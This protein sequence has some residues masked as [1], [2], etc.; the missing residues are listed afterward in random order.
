MCPPPVNP[1]LSPVATFYVLAISLY[2]A[3]VLVQV[4]FGGPDPE[5]ERNLLAA[6]RS[7]HLF[8]VPGG[9][10][11]SQ[12]EAAGAAGRRRVRRR[13]GLALAVCCRALALLSWLRSWCM[14]QQLPALLRTVCLALA[15]L[16]L[17]GSWVSATGCYLSYASLLIAA[18][19]LS[20]FWPGMA[21]CTLLHYIAGEHGV[22]VLMQ[23]KC[24]C[25][26]MSTLLHALLQGLTFVAA[27]C[28]GAAYLPL[29]LGSSIAMP[30]A[31]ATLLVAAGR[32]A[33]SLSTSAGAG[34]GGCGSR[35][36][37]RRAAVLI[38]CLL[39]AAYLAAAERTAAALAAAVLRSHSMLHLAAA[40]LTPTACLPHLLLV[41]L[42]LEAWAWQAAACVVL[43]AGGQR[44]LSLMTRVL[45]EG[46]AGAAC[47]PLDLC[48]AWL[49]L[50]IVKV[51]RAAAF[52]LQISAGWICLE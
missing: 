42:S 5:E 12:P 1:P 19:V 43:A 34:G 29:L 8:Y 2:H 26:C 31:W 24:G 50:A 37:T 13:R 49:Q 6:C 22:G 48:H 15:A 23:Q 40:M 9:R 38:G 4:P 27:S 28:A 51:G 35:R 39:D 20:S 10:S 47:W 21:A 7:A 17:P 25:L 16:T 45:P 32:A 3:L 18:Q 52:C 30:P 44:Q 33:T 41:V 46:Q 11:A 36:L 14:R